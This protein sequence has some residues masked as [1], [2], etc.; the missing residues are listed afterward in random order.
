MP[1]IHA[2]SAAGRSLLDRAAPSN[3]YGGGPALGAPPLPL[4]VLGRGFR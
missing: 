1:A 2:S 4:L 3:G